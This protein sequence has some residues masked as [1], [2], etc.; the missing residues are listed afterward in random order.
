MGGGK[1][2]IYENP[3]VPAFYKPAPGSSLS[4]FLLLLYSELS[5]FSSNCCFIFFPIRLLLDSVCDFLG[6]LFRTLSNS[7]FFHLFYPILLTFLPLSLVLNVVF[8]SVS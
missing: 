6:V 2:A 4:G 3:I 1:I 7:F 5:S 8:I